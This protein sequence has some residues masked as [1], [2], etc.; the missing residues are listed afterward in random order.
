MNAILIDPSKQTVESIDIAKHSILSVLG[1]KVGKLYL[2]SG[3]VISFGE[4][5]NNLGNDN[6]QSG[7]SIS[8]Y[9]FILHGRAILTGNLGPDE[10]IE[11]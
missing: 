10:K 3:A 8:G 6:S 11:F 9:K 4:D 1:E 7:W 2:R 5:F